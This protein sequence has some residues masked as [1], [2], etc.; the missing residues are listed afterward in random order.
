M[1]QVKASLEKRKLYAPY[2]GVVGLRYVSEGDNITPSSQVASIVNIDRLKLEFAVPEKYFSVVNE[3]DSVRFTIT[4][5]DSTYAALVYA[6]EPEIDPETRSVILRAMFENRESKIFPGVFAF[7]N[8]A[9]SD[10]SNAYMIPTQSLVPELKGQKVYMMEN[11]KISE[12]TVKTGIRTERM[13][14]L[15][16]GVEAGDSVLTTGILQANPGQTIKVRNVVN[17][18]YAQ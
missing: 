6:I 18:R 13:I 17:D 7:V 8:Y 15:T 16:D 3:G 1:N 14:Q 5:S 10:I 12:K 2:D 11:G 4:G 9:L